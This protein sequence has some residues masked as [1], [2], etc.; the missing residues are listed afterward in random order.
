MEWWENT[1][2]GVFTHK[3]QQST[4]HNFYADIISRLVT[5]TSTAVGMMGAVFCYFSFIQGNATTVTSGCIKEPE[6]PS[7]G[8]LLAQ[9]HE[10]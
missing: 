10:L 9:L 3:M 2:S 8:E 6:L 4:Q 7:W 1:N 5:I